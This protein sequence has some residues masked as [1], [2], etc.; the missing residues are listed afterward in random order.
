MN[1]RIII[2]RWIVPGIKNT[3]WFVKELLTEG[4]CD[5]AMVFGW[6]GKALTDKLSYAAFS[7]GIMIM[8]WLILKKHEYGVEKH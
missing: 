8:K 5:A 2:D 6:V 3:P 4:E 1:P 7:M